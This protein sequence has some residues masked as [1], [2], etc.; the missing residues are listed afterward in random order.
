MD[1]TSKEERPNAPD[2]Q[3]GFVEMPAPTYFP[4]FTAVGVVLLGAGIVT[5][6]IL[7]GIG[8]VFAI[9][10]AWGWAKAAAQ[11]EV[12]VPLVPVDERAGPVAPSDKEVMSVSVEAVGHR[13]LL[14]GTLHPYRAGAYGGVVGGVLMVAVALL[15]GL[16]SGHGIWYP[17]NLL[18]GMV[19]PSYQG[20]SVHFL[21]QFHWA[22]LG[23]GFLIHALASIGIGMLY[24]MLLPMLPGRAF[25]WGGIVGPLLWSG[26]VYAFMSVLNP[27]L[28]QRV[29]WPWFFASQ[30]AF[31]IA[32]GLVVERVE[33]VPAYAVGAESSRRSD[34]ASGG[35]R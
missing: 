33:K 11:P 24:A 26:G 18:A 3:E 10:G 30:F 17:V 2:A 16:V 7:S 4:M 5:N 25:P 34:D 1:P 12:E 23:V 14:P 9:V 22:G 32:A 29:S 28:E 15:Y 27:I 21:E 31:G 19:I 8:A 20:V 35:D 13:A 6:V